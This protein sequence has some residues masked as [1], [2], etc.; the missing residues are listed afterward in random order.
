MAQQDE[1]EKQEVFIKTIL[2]WGFD[3]DWREWHMKVKAV[4]KKRAGTVISSTT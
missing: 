3:K 1:T 2:F 4:A